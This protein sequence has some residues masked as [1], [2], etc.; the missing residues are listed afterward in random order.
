MELDQPMLKEIGIKKIGDRIRIANQ[1]KKFRLEHYTV[2]KPVRIVEFRAV[3]RLVA[4]SHSGIHCKHA[5]TE[6]SLFSVWL[7]KL[8]PKRLNTI[9]TTHHRSR[10]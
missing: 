2:K 5:S 9:I 3:V 1:I 7:F 6:F 8:V 4:N 10:T